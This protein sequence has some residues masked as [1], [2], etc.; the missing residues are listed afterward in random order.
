MSDIRSFDCNDLELI[1]MV[2]THLRY[3]LY[4]AIPHDISVYIAGFVEKFRN[5]EIKFN[6]LIDFSII[7]GTIIK[8]GTLYNSFHLECLDNYDD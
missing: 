7:N 3:N 6:D 4:P 2:D 5:K 8:A 1:Q